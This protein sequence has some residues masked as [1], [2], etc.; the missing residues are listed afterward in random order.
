MSPDKSYLP[1]LYEYKLDL[2]K[3][4]FVKPNKSKIL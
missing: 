3:N 4:K 1:T 2:F